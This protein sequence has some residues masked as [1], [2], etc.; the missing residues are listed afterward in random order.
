MDIFNEAILSEKEFDLLLLKERE[1]LKVNLQKSDYL[2][3]NHFFKALYGDNHPY[4]Y[5]YE[6][7][8]L[9]SDLLVPIKTFYKNNLFICR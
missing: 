8:D 5:T 2:A 4:G 7:E 6:V 3:S 9:K 1:S